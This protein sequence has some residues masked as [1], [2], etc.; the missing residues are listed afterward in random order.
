MRV[1]DEQVRDSCEGKHLRSALSG[2]GERSEVGR[3]QFLEVETGLKVVSFSEPDLKKRKWLLK[4]LSM[5]EAP[6]DKAWERRKRQE[7][8]GSRTKNTRPRRNNFHVCDNITDDDLHELK[9]CIELGFGFNEED[10]QQLCHTLPALDLYF[11]VNRQLSPSPVSTP[12][13]HRS[14]S[15]ASPATATPPSDSDSWKI[16]NPDIAG[17]PFFYSLNCNLVMDEGDDPEHVKIKLRYW[18][19]AV[20]CSVMQSH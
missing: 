11:A 4:Q 1:I 6:R 2:C 19:Q 5:C 8:G 3:G 17:K 10:G 14:S 16:C 13:S 15:F 7:R 9:G 18:A 20:A 12:L